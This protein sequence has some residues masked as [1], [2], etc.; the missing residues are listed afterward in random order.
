MLINM[1]S[2][3]TGLYYFRMPALDGFIV[4]NSKYEYSIS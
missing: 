4:C 2:Y 1:L 3:L